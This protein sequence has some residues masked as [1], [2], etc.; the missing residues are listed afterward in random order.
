[1]VL[2]ANDQF[3]G[4]YKD[5]ST[6][7]TKLGARY[8]EASLG[9]FKQVDPSWQEENSYL[10]AQGDPCNKIDPTGLLT[11]SEIVGLIG[12]AQSG[13]WTVALATAGATA[14]IS[15]GVGLAYGLFWCAVSNRGCANLEA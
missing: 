3:T 8:Y 2:R 13:V 15:L 4:G 14:G 10:Y 12:L 5:A 1:M 6:G 7:Q 11:C 9:R